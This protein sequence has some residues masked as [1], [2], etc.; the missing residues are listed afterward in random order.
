MLKG[1]KMPKHAD[2]SS[3]CNAFYQSKANIHY[4]N[5]PIQIRILKISPP[6]P[7]SFQIKKTLIFFHISAQ[8]IDCGYSSEPPRRSNLCIG[9]FS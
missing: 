8:N 1:R 6:K 4:E 2:R 9:V 5:T 3:L 7:G